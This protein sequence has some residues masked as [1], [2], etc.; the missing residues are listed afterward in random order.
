MDN[1]TANCENVE[2]LKKSFDAILNE[3]HSLGLSVHLLKDKSIVFPART[4]EPQIFDGDEALEHFNRPEFSNKVL[5]FGSQHFYCHSE[6]LRLR[7]DYFEALF[8]GN[9]Q[10]TCMDLI[11]IELPASSSNIELLLRYLYTGKASEKLFYG[12]EIF[13]T[14]ENCNYLGVHELVSLAVEAFA[15][16]WKSLVPSSLFRRSVVD[17]NFVRALLNY[18]SKRAI[19]QDGDK[20][21]IVV[22]WSA[23]TD[24]DVSEARS[25]I[26]ESNCLD[27][28]SL[29]DLEWSMEANPH[30]LT[31]LDFS[32]FRNV[33]R[34]A[35]REN[36]EV[37]KSSKA[38][39]E[40]AKGLLECVRILTK[41]LEEVRCTKCRMYLPRAAMKTRTCVKMDHLGEYTIHQGWSC[42]KQLKKKSKGCKPAGVSRH[43]PGRSSSSSS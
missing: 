42:C 34:R 29:T 39:E 18:G 5:A 16:R 41:Q 4:T 38:A 32:N 40:K 15:V 8:T 20:L 3:I 2:S 13:K 19:F 35:R 9:Y 14:I 11:S 37:K 7:S 43:A 30:L 26:L 31:E 23:K 22:N 27:T 25:L 1:A 17:L 24:S 36:E 33:C 10:E 28:A 21:K 12:V 6:Y